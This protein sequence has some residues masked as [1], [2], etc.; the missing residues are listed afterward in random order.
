V[1]RRLAGVSRRLVTRC[2]SG[3][4]RAESSG[5]APGS[6]ALGNELAV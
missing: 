2:A 1:S 5:P 4:I 6:A 3:R